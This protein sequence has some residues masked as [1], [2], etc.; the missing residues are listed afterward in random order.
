LGVRDSTSLEKLLLTESSFLVLLAEGARTAAAGDCEILQ[1]GAFEVVLLADFRALHPE[2]DDAEAEATGGAD[3]EALCFF[4]LAEDLRVQKR[5][6]E[7]LRR[8]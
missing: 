2:G 5:R 6:F 1:A 7:G 8:C 3:E 4:L